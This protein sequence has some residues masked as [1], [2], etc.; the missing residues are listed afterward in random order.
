[1]FLFIVLLFISLGQVYSKETSNRF[2][3]LLEDFPEY[4]EDEIAYADSCLKKNELKDEEEKILFL[5][6]EL[7]NNNVPSWMQEKYQ[8][9]ENFFSTIFS[10]DILLKSKIGIEFFSFII[11]N[12]PIL[13]KIKENKKNSSIKDVFLFFRKQQDK[14]IFFAGMLFAPI[15][16]DSYIKNIN[17]NYTPRANAQLIIKENKNNIISHAKEINVFLYNLIGCFD[18]DVITNNNANQVYQLIYS[19]SFYRKE[20]FNFIN[21]SFLACEK[22]EKNIKNN[23]QEYRNEVIKEMFKKL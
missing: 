11:S 13:K 21:T 3:E 14:D 12:M 1:M 15:V 16:I 17:K 10:S 20:F 2:K 9:K 4:S 22:F 7:Y 18:G 6:K 23:N 5:I 19:S 8:T